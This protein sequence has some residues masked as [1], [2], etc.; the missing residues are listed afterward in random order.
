MSLN[1]NMRLIG[2]LVRAALV[3]ERRAHPDGP[4]GQQGAPIRQAHGPR[5]QQNAA[6]GQQLGA[7]E[8]VVAAVRIGR[9]KRAVGPPQ[10]PVWKL[11][12]AVGQPRRQG[13]P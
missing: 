2:W 12:G 6:V 10:P 4:I 13:N 3:L 5:R 9:G 11:D 8:E 1:M 7:V